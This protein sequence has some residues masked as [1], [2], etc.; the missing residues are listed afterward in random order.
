MILVVVCMLTKGCIFIPCSQEISSEGTARLVFDRVVPRKGLFRKVVS[1]RGPQF[2]GPFLTS[3]Y[4]LLEIE[5]N[6]STAYH[7]QTDG[8][9]ERMN[10]ELEKYLRMFVNY[11]QTDWA[12][13]LSSAEF[14]LNTRVNR[15]TG[16]S[17]FF[18]EHGRHPYD[19]FTPKKV[20][21]KVESAEEFA[22]SMEKTLDK[23]KWAL[24]KSA[25]QMEKSWNA[26]NRPA[27]DYKPGDKVMLD[28]RNIRSTRPSNKLDD[29]WYGPF[30][31]IEKVGALAYRL[32]IPRNWSGIHNVFNESLLK[33]FNPPTDDLRKDLHPRPPPDVVQEQ[34]E[35]EVDQLLDVRK[36]R[37]RWEYFVSWKGYPRSEAT[38]EPLKNLIPGTTEFIQEFALA[39][40]TLP[41]LNAIANIEHMPE[42]YLAIFYDEQG[43]ERA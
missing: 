16:Y 41:R 18:L 22:K 34:L 28:A 14:A 17:P 11:K 9:T 19:G 42:G 30:E 29:K 27:K 36:Y 7:P 26:R 21:V 1:D 25:V 20:K 3:L 6:P 13:W 24:E 23:A 4:K 32:D 12:D 33:P 2:I 40:P 39:N 35:W 43:K 37:N 38:W 10:Q 5:G 8:Q 31:V 15:A